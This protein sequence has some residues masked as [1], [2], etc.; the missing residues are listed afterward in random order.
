MQ[1]TLASRLAEARR[2]IREH[3]ALSGRQDSD[4]TLMAVSKTR[5]YETILEAYEAGQRI[6]GENRVQEI[7]DKFPLPS[8]RPT[9]MRLHL[10]GHLQSNKV[11]KVVPLVD[12]ID[13][14]H[15]LRL[16][17]QISCVAMERGRVMPILLEYNTS[18]ESS[19]SGFT[20]EDDLFSAVEAISSLGG[21]KIR[22]L[23]TIG[24]LEGDEDAVR[25]AFR[26]LRSLRDECIKRF[27]SQDFSV[28]SMGMSSDY[29]VAV[30]EGSTLVRLGTT[31]FGQRET[32]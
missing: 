28:L 19:K 3:V 31:L 12:A 6:F 23:M 29:P 18:G 4:I 32:L 10:I 17:G 11:R 7:V 15:S 2:T 20:T 5:P 13:S 1:K 14:V 16:A 24:P 9:G 27:P 30:E 26:R 8:E 21:V 25:R 22:G